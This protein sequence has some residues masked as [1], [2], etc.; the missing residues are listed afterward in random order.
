MHI[1]N[2]STRE[3]AVHQ[4]PASHV[5]SRQL[6]FGHTMKAAFILC[7]MLAVIAPPTR[8]QNEER[9][10]E[11]A[12]GGPCGVVV[13]TRQIPVSTAR[14][15]ANVVA[16]RVERRQAG[17]SEWTAVATLSAPSSLDELRLRLVQAGMCV[18]NPFTANRAKSND[19]WNMLQ[20]KGEPPSFGLVG[21]SLQFRLAVG[22]ATVDSGARRGALYEY[23]V[24]HL[25]KTGDVLGAYISAPTAWP[26]SQTLSAPRPHRADYRRRVDHPALDDSRQ[27]RTFLLPCVSQGAAL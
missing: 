10:A 21:A 6:S 19:I 24:S 3:I 14:P 22:M 7:A 5:Q 27:H 9:D 2:C 1:P 4:A 8:A 20:K 25:S 23:R 11:L 13:S 18:P 16:C 26:R 17:E 12:V 15:Y